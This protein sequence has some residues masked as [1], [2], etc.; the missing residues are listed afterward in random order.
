[1]RNP[2]VSIPSF[3]STSLKAILFGLSAI[4][5]ATSALSAQSLGYE[6]STGIFITPLAATA[7]S[8]AHGAGKPVVAT[9]VLAGGPVIGT[10]STFSVTEG[11]AKHVEVGYTR[12]FH[13]TGDDKALSSLWTD[14]FDI[15]HGK[16]NLIPENAGKTKWVPAVSVGGVLR[17]NDTNVL[18]GVN[19]QSKTNGDVYVVATKVITQIE[20]KVPILVNAGV[21]GTN[22]SL[23]GTWSFG[24]S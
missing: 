1:M 2:V 11:F 19:G 18:N 16:V 6:G 12:E 7:A 21:R 15:F 20:K 5:L 10:W 14:G 24:A 4:A 8:P 13:A 22:A 17:I 9:H 23:W 3:F